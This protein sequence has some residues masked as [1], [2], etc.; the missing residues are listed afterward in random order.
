VLSTSRLY[1]LIAGIL[2][3]PNFKGQRVAV[4]LSGGTYTI[5]LN[6]GMVFD[7]T[8][9]GDGTVTV[10]GGDSTKCMQYQVNAVSSG[11]YNFT[12]WSMSGVTIYKPNGGTILSLVASGRTTFGLSYDGPAATLDVYPVKMA[13][14]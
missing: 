2:K 11:S 4:S 13:A 12:S 5:N 6:L 10:T 9:S 14:A 3:W 7:L 8:V 1:A